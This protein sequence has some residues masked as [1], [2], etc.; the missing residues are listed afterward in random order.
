[1]ANDHISEKEILHALDGELPAE[2]AN[3]V[4]DHTTQCDAC[5]SKWVRFA[6]LS[7]QIAEMERAEGSYPARQAALAALLAGIAKAQ[8]GLRMRRMVMRMVSVAAA[9]VLV[10]AVMLRPGPAPVATGLSPAVSMGQRLVSSDQALP[11]GYLSL[12]FADPDLP[13]DEASV[14]PVEVSREDLRLIGVQVDGTAER[15]QAEIV[16]GM[17]GWPR[18]I[19]IME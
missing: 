18:A 5:R 1:M 8:R 19:R 10:A 16:L 9:A 13:L 15:V 14:L 6:N 12:P 7:G 4:R 17:D 2:Q 11:D 3:M